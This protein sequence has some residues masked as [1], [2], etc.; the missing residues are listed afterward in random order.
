[1]IAVFDNFIKDAALLKEIEKNK[2][3][4]FKEPGVFKW[5]NG[6]WNSPATNTA[7]KIIEYA[8]GDNCPI[9]DIY[10][11]DGFEYWTGIQK[12]KLPSGEKDAGM[13][14]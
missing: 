3:E 1:M 14:S 5:Y 11:V 2:V 12:A 10:S 8:W 6:W 9:S 13:I 7:K 4:L